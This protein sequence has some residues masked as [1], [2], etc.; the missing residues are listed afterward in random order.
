MIAA[1]HPQV[2]ENKLREKCQIESYEQNHGGDTRQKFRIHSA[3][4]LGPPEVQSAD[5]SRYS[6]A[7][8]DVVEMGDHEVGVVQMNVQPQTGEE[9]A[10]QAADQ[11][12]SDEA[13]RVEHGRIVGNRAFV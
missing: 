9:Q 13:Q 2:A 10:G 6:A 11:E 8:H 1:W 4:D 5:V 7:H 3:G 12:K